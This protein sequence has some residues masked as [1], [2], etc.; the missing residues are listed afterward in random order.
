[1]DGQH[2]AGGP[3]RA[4][5]SPRQLRMAT[6]QAPKAW[7]GKQESGLTEAGKVAPDILAVFDLSDPFLQPV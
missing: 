1:M 5:S 3:C 6:L 2:L 7:A 4:F